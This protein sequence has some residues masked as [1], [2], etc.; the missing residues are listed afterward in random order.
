M[1]S[2]LF[3][4]WIYICFQ[5]LTWFLRKQM[6]KN[7]LRLRSQMT[8]KCLD[9]KTRYKSGTIDDE[10]IKKKIL[11]NYLLMHIH[12]FDRKHNVAD[13]YWPY[14]F[15]SHFRQKEICILVLQF[16]SFIFSFFLY[17]YDGHM[18]SSLYPLLFQF[19]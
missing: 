15:V 9:R 17:I 3:Y 4:V 19:L 10:A 12:M 1:N 5:G 11:F 18:N 16:D 2:I 6:H 7:R 14:F 13:I 8:C